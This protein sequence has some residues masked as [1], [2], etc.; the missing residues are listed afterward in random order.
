MK[1]Q[2]IQV[3]LF[4]YIN[5]GG[6][7]M[8]FRLLKYFLIVAR[9]ENITRAANW[10]HIT[11]PTLS[12]QLMQLE[13]ELGVKLFKRSKHRIIL[14]DDGMMLKRRAQEIMALVE[15]TKQDFIAEDKELA[16]KIAI[17]CGETRNMSFLSKHIKAFHEMYPRV[18]YEI[19]SATAD[20]IKDDLEKGILDM[21]LLTEPVDIGKYAFIRMPEKEQWGVLV[22]KDSMLAQKEFVTPEDLADVPLLIGRREEVRNELLNWFGEYGERAK[23]IATY[24]LILNAA[25]M[26]KNDVGVAL[27][28]NLGNIYE[29][30]QLVPLKPALETGAV[31][32]WKRNNMLSKAT[33]RFID[34]IKNTD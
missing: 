24:N 20:D 1:E 29:D 19:Y 34:F 12:R 30:L 17:G 11:Q 33:Q 25:N 5:Q 28:F 2:S 7:I 9:E 32:V 8:E 23:F 13:D 10:L 18:K 21:G 6:A 14:T 26:V 22:R 4:L 16:G 31:L 3:A 27:G 15:K